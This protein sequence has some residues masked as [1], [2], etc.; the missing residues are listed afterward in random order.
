MLT[1]VWWL[2]GGSAGLWIVNDE[3]LGRLVVKIG[4]K[5]GR[6]QL[7]IELGQRKGKVVRL[8]IE[9]SQTDGAGFLKVRL[10]RVWPVVR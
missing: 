5:L 2:Q 4:Q 10:F 7:G 9:P 3:S 6:I 1:D 8:R